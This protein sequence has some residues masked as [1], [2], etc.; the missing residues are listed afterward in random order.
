MKSRSDEERRSDLPQLSGDSDNDVNA[1][2]LTEGS[3]E[4]GQA[5][6]HRRIQPEKR[7]E[8]EMGAVGLRCV[9]QW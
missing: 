1:L 5:M 4:S 6:E 3:A 7:V 8:L 9:D 2:T